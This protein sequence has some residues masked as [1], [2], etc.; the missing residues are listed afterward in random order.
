MTATTASVVWGMLKVY[1]LYGAMVA[2]VVLCST[3]NPVTALQAWAVSTVAVYCVFCATY[4][5]LVT[6]EQNMEAATSARIVQMRQESI[7][8]GK[9]RQNNALNV[10]REA[11]DGA[12]GDA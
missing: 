7:D 3:W 12:N 10:V 11:M 4:R 8:A 2:F 6:F 9:V 1:G 5:A